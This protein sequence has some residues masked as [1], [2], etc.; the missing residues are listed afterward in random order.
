MILNNV[1]RPLCAHFFH[2]LLFYR[3]SYDQSPFPTELLISTWVNDWPAVALNTG[4]SVFH[5]VVNIHTQ[6][7]NQPYLETSCCGLSKQ[8][9]QISCHGWVMIQKDKMHHLTKPANLATM[10]Y[11]QCGQN[12]SDS[13]IPD[14]CMDADINEIKRVKVFPFVLSFTYILF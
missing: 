12:A 2:H 7:I 10:H 13:S 9:V 6:G 3:V 1:T 4:A 11:W 5:W 14:R 8:V